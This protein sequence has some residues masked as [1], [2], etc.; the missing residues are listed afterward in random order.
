MSEQ[1]D[2]GD[3]GE[4]AGVDRSGIASLDDVPIAPE[5]GG[6]GPTMSGAGLRP[7]AS[8]AG[9]GPSNSPFAGIDLRSM[10]RKLGRVAAWAAALF[11]VFLISAWVSLPTRSIAWRI[12]HEARKAG[13]ILT[14]DD[15]SIRPWGS[16]SLTGVTWSFKPSRAD[17]MPVPFVIDELDISFSV[18]KYLLFKTIDVDFEGT[19]DEGSVA[20]AF[21]QSDDE[22]RIAFKI[23]DLP[24]YSVPKLQDSVNAP[25][26]G[27]FAIDVNMAAPNNEWAKATGRLEVHCYSCT[28]GDGETKLYVPGTKKT[29]MLA[30]GVTIPLIDLGTLDGVLEIADGKAVAEEFGTESTDIVFKISGE[31]EFKDPIAH[32]RLDLLIK[33][34]IDPSLRQR[35]DNIDLLVVTANPQVLMDPPDEGWIGVVLEGNLKHR[36][37]RGV[38]SKSKAEQIRD[39]RNEQRSQAKDR[40]EQRARQRAQKRPTEPAEPK[41]KPEP[42]PEP[43]QDDEN[44]PVPTGIGER[45]LE[46]EIAELPQPEVGGDELEDEGGGDGEEDEVGEQL[47]EHEGGDDGSDETSLPQ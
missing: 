25:V 46:G 39:K 4:R 29:S 18:L 10:G 17:S 16:A 28:I 5:P 30:K 26:R 42:E 19:L 31:V 21:Y 2:K 41:P 12:S 14:V 35:S 11:F 6:V 27:T 7:S 40:A 34:F 13:F 38:K 47:G 15:V 23:S 3:L 45:Q 24:L 22:S 32:S 33:V 9:L 44:P 1:P 43:D 8:M 36:R 37:F 20:G